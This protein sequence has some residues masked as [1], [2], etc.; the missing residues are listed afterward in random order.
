MTR[1][2]ARSNAVEAWAILKEDGTL[3]VRG[4]RNSAPALYDSVSCAMGMMCASETAVRVLI[5]P[6]PTRS[7]ARKPRRKA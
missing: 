3:L 7:P 6:L 2:Q 4:N 1:R 5:T